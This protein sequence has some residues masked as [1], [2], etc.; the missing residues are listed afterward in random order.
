[1]SGPVAGKSRVPDPEQAA[2]LTKS[3]IS[4]AL[5]RA[6]RRDIHDK[7][8]ALQAVL[9]AEPLRQST[10]IQAAYAAIVTSE[11][12]VIETLNTQIDQLGQVVSA[13][14]GR[15][16][17]AEIYASQPGLGTILAA[18]VLGEFGD[19]RTA[20]STPRHANAT[21]A[22][23]PSPAPQARRRSC[24]PATPATDAWATH[25]SNGRSAQCAA[26]PEPRPT[27]NNYAT[28]TSA[29]KRHCANSPTGSSASCTAASKPTPPT[30]NTQPGP[31]TPK[32]PLDT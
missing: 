32:P 22:P 23:H 5:R 12:A 25:C 27:A 4:A 26:L 10:V 3:T 28:A 21:P 20:T 17:D 30:T 2:Q 29:T 9:H 18:R 13:H 24:S 15:H 11:V 8:T 1:M 19:D 31:T 16:R 14:F 6:N 7:A